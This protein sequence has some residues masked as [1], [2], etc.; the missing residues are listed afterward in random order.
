MAQN[1]DTLTASEWLL[2]KAVWKRGTATVRQIHEEVADHTG[3]AYTTVKTML[4][5]MEKKK[6]L[7]VDRV[8]PV[9]Q[10]SARKQQGDLVPRAIER[11]L[12]SVLD[13]SLAP[14]VPYIAKSRGLTED[15]VRQLKRILEEE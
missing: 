7:K 10:F 11:F 15:E 4:E 12:D 13:D 14:L 1:H 5:R 8:G 6:L 3:W 9:K 2:I